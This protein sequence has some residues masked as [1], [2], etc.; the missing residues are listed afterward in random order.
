MRLMPDTIINLELAVP[1]PPDHDVIG[2]RS[3]FLRSA[4][5]FPDRM[6]LAFGGTGF[7]KDAS[8]GRL[9]PN[10]KPLEGQSYE[11][12]LAAIL[13]ERL[14]G[15]QNEVEYVVTVAGTKAVE[16]Q[17]CLSNTMNVVRYRK[18]GVD[19]H[20]LLH[21]GMT[22]AFLEE[23]P[24]EFGAA[25]HVEFAPSVVTA[26]YVLD[27]TDAENALSGGLD[28][29]ITDFIAGINRMVAALLVSIPAGKLP[30]LTP[31]YDRGS[32][33]W[34][35]ML[36]RGEGN[37]FDAHRVATSLL[38]TTLVPQPLP[39]EGWQMF[40]TVVAGH[41]ELDPALKA[42]RSAASFIQAGA[43]DFALL[44]TAVAVEV[45]TSQYVNGRLRQEG[46]SKTKLSEL[47]ADLTFNIMLNTQVTPLAPSGNKPDIQLLGAMN[48][49][50]K[51]RNDYMHY[52]V[53]AVT[54]EEVV[55]LAAEAEK[56]VSYLHEVSHADGLTP[57]SS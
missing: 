27:G 46:V 15:P 20:L 44:L 22:K 34:I 28:A 45:A 51:L 2:E 35:Y 54:R 21:A 32:F 49:L 26:R 24:E 38:R 18:N 17:F 36:I 6:V 33:P 1:T 37:Q 41:A 5:A 11:I 10:L 7:T 42:L 52:G 39:P 53:F 9:F 55:K 25:A 14:P 56:F 40:M 30:I 13:H 29:A 50:R 47:K 19:R 23:R 57:H 48:R 43:L 16:H 31:V 12:E 3:W 8:L 4:A